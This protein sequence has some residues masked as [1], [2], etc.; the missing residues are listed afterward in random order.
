MRRLVLLCV[1]LAAGALVLPV[2]ALAHDAPENGQSRFVM[3]D[4]MIETFLV[5]ALAALVA[6]MWAWKAGMFHNL[7]EQA[8]IPLGI[9]E[10]DYYTPEWALDEEEW[11]DAER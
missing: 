6:F 4:W 3:V 7:S 9:E 1:F 11:V 2:D 8:R 10:P 5:F